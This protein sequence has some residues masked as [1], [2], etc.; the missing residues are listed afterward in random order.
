MD[1]V[2][3][4]TFQNIESDTGQYCYCGEGCAV[5]YS[6]KMGSPNVGQGNEYDDRRWYPISLTVPNVVKIKR[7]NCQDDVGNGDS[8]PEKLKY[9]SLPN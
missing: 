9:H 8:W 4:D 7:S 2:F 3:I 5:K 1:M 6:A